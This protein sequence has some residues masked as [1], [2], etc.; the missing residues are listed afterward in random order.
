V[1]YASS[2]V[3]A[4]ALL[5]AIAWSFLDAPARQVILLSAGI[6]VVVQVVAFA[7]ARLLLRKSVLVGWGLGSALRL[8]VLVVFAVIM[9]RTARAALTPALLSFVGFLFVTTVIEPIFLKQ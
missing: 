5:T 9:A 1:L 7:V 6:A 4:I 2:C 8:V 3:V